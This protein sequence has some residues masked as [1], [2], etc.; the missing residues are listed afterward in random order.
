MCLH[1]ISN[2]YDAKLIFCDKKPCNS[3]GYC[4]ETTEGYLCEY[5]H[6]QNNALDICDNYP[7][8][9]ELQCK[10]I[11]IYKKNGYKCSCP[12][13]NNECKSNIPSLCKNNKD[14]CYNGGL[15]NMNANNS[16]T[17]S[18]K[19][20]KYEGSFCTDIF[21]IKSQ[22]NNKSSGR[23]QNKVKK[24]PHFGLQRNNSISYIM[25]INIGIMFVVCIILSIICILPL[26]Y[27][28]TIED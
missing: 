17:C 12:N 3:T 8:G 18:C 23:I 27:F 2:M 15:C 6:L 14:I 1:L 20:G 22:N 26:L 24:S 9:F 5:K 7:C 19:K 21:K 11:N 13:K 16:Y 28:K 25:L 10:L 4:K